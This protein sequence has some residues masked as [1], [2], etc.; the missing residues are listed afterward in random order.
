[1][2]GSGTGE[3]AEP[4]LFKPLEMS[5]ASTL[6]ANTGANPDKND[7][8]VDFVLVDTSMGIAFVAD[9][10]GHGYPSTGLPARQREA[11]AEC[12]AQFMGAMQMFLRAG[13]TRG[14]TLDDFDAH[15][16]SKLRYASNT[17]ESMGKTSTFSM[18]IVLTE[19]RAKA[20]SSSRR[21]ILSTSIA[22][23]GIVLLKSSS[24][25]ALA[26]VIVCRQTVAQ[27]R[28]RW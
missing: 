25:R 23:S 2:F 19:F 28:N 1:M 14:I 20:T 16:R 12:W 21:W 4:L 6:L 17:F 5:S 27:H 11:T 3:A 26:F 7:G 13:R 15:I 10:V 22:D 8:N 24:G 18:A 9:G